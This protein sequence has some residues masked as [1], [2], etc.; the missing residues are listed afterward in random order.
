MRPIL[1]IFTFLML[2]IPSQAS[3]PLCLAGCVKADVDGLKEVADA[4]K[5]WAEILPGLNDALHAGVQ[6]DLREMDRVAT[7]LVDTLDRT[8]GKNL[9]LTDQTV[10]G[11]MA[12]AVKQINAIGDHALDNYKQALFSTECTVQSVAD[13]FQ[14][15]IE[16]AIPRFQWIRSFF[17]EKFNVLRSKD[18]GGRTIEVT[19]DPDSKTERF[20]AAYKLATLKLNSMSDATRMDQVL[21]LALDRQQLA[22]SYYCATRAG[23]GSSEGIG[24]VY[25]KL[26]EARS[27]YLALSNLTSFVGR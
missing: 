8:Y 25:E 23:V 21:A 18:F 2:A 26:L 20:Q 7:N 16:E 27:E 9:D 6:A 11:L 22:W 10:R 14:G 3:S 5:R 15:K 13:I 19:F 24:H 12:E 4:M 17:G 1:T